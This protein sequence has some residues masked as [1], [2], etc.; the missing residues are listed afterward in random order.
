MLTKRNIL[1][2]LSTFICLFGLAQTAKSERFEVNNDIGYAEAVKVGN[3]IYISGRVGWG[4]MKEALRRSYI[5][6]E[7]T[8][9]H[10][11][12]T[13]ENI[14]KENIY[15]TSLDSVIKNKDVRKEFYKNDHFPAATWV[16]VKRLFSKDFVVEIEAVALINEQKKGQSRK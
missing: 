7:S 10:Y 16:E 4:D 8:L 1:L 2:V 15:T 6:I 5:S 9:K 12:A 11:H 14:I 13:F 3:T